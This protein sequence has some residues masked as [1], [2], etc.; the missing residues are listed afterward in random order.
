MTRCIGRYVSRR[1]CQLCLA[2]RPCKTS[3]QSCAHKWHG[4]LVAAF[5]R[6]PVH[7]A[8]QKIAL[9]ARIIRCRHR[10]AAVAQEGEIRLNVFTLQGITICGKTWPLPAVT[11]LAATQYAFGHVVVYSNRRPVFFFSWRNSADIFLAQTKERGGRCY[12]VCSEA[13]R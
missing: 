7:L 4:T 8:T 10:N 5:S 2:W 3:F 9:S 12:S 13:Y 11:W 1:V 6:R